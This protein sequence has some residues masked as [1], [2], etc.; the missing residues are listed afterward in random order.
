[1]LIGGLDKPFKQKLKQRLQKAGFHAYITTQK[2]LNGDL[3]DNIINKNKRR[4]GAQLELTTSLRKS[5]YGINNPKGRRT[6]TNAD[7]WLFIDTIRESIEQYKVQL[8][9]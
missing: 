1:C 6:S 2:A 5:F 3:P 9:V 4:A 8:S 7:F